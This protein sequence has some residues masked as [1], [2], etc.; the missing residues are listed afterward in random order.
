MTIY[1][2]EMSVRNCGMSRDRWLCTVH[3]IWVPCRMKILTTN[4]GQNYGEGFCMFNNCE[5]RSLCIKTDGVQCEVHLILRFTFGYVMKT[6]LDIWVVFFPD[7]IWSIVLT[8]PWHINSSDLD[9]NL[10]EDRLLSASFLPE[11]NVSALQRISKHV[12]I[13]R[14]QE[15]S[16]LMLMVI[17][18]HSTDV[19][20]TPLSISLEMS[21]LWITAL[22]TSEQYDIVGGKFV[23]YPAHLSGPVLGPRTQ[24]SIMNTF[25]YY[26]LYFCYMKMVS[27]S[28]VNITTE[29][30]WFIQFQWWYIRPDLCTV[31]G[32]TGIWNLPAFCSPILVP[33]P[34]TAI[35]RHFSELR[36][37][38][39]IDG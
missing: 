7:G 31:G 30:F 10:E 33:H 21:Q 3:D 22:H 26:F 2:Y 38:P 9:Q 13:P 6:I 34:N 5:M 24:D 16:C 14:N 27:N 32:D 25:F 4:G 15:T 8:W 39:H 11:R 28:S 19:G 1:K 37:V 23:W 20:G 17:E 35:L 29:F 18:T 12:Y 36:D